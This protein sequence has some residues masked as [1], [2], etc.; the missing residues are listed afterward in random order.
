MGGTYTLLILDLRLEDLQDNILAVVGDALIEEELA[1]ESTA[2]PT[3]VKSAEVNEQ[4]GSADVK[5][6]TIKVAPTNFDI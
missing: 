4:A 5:G 1:A 3:I 6:N 2:K